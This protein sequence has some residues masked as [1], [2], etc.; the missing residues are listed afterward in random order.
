MSCPVGGINAM[1]I[2]RGLILGLT[3]FSGALVG[4]QLALR[5]PSVWLRQVFVVVE[6][7]H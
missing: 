5:V 6:R 4:G 7:S 3:M 1:V 2:T